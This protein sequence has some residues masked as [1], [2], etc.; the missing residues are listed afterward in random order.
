[1]TCH[2]ITALKPTVIHSID[3]HCC[4]L[5]YNEVLELSNSFLLKFV[6]SIL[7]YSLSALFVG[8]GGSKSQ[9]CQG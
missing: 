4:G 8:G 5:Q 7:G 1:M 3:K 2:D 9:E 6:S